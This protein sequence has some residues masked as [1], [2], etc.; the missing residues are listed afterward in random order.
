MIV[1][2]K[3]LTDTLYADWSGWSVNQVLLGMPRMFEASY[4]FRF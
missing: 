4:Q 2:G 1:R 3:N